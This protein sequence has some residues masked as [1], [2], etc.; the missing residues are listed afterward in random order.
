LDRA[1]LGVLVAYGAFDAARK[2][3]NSR[4]LAAGHCALRGLA[5]IIAL[6]VA[7]LL[8]AG[9]ATVRS[10]TLVRLSARSERTGSCA[11]HQRL[12][13]PGASALQR[14]TSMTPLIT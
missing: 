6:S 7:A 5:P 4:W 13:R 1:R 9:A 10:S 3:A 8:A 14:M 11:K 12:G 2:S